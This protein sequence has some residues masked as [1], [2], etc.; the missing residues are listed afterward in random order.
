MKEWPF[1]KLGQVFRHP[2]G[3]ELV[4]IALRGDGQHLWAARGTRGLA[5]RLPL[6]KM[7]A[8]WSYVATGEAEPEEEV[9]HL[10]RA[11]LAALRLLT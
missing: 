10:C 5:T 8:D 1:V 7:T 9:E 11:H 6:H 2:A 4:C 3:N